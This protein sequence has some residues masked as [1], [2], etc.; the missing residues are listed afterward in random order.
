M[1]LIAC[2]DSETRLVGGS[3]VQMLGCWLGVADGSPVG[4][5]EGLIDGIWLG[6]SEGVNEGATVGLVLGG[7]LGMS[8]GLK[9]GYPV[10]TELGLELGPKELLGMALGADVL[11]LTIHWH[12]ALQTSMVVAVSS[13]QTGRARNI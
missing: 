3:V 10:G 1:M 9:D 7:L 11:R 5:Q 12:G 8:L 4:V 6:K 13:S 2:G